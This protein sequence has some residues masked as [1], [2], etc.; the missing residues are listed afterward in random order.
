FG[1]EFDAAIADPN[2]SAVVLDT[3]CPGG[4]AAGTPE[5]ASKIRAA[6][7][8]KPIIAVAN[9]LMASAA[10]WIASAADEIVATPSADVGSVGGY[11]AHLDQSQ[12]LEKEG[13]K[14]TFIQEPALK[15]A[16]N[17]YE[18]LRS[19]ARQRRD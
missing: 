17:P 7:G 16:G 13:L 15:T 12:A 9:A 5:L 10:Y 19:A 11:Q 3:D 2:V 1:Q 14:V 18:P 8:K 4:S 6:R